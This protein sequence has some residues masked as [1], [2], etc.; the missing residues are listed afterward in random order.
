M[1]RKTKIVASLTI[2]LSG[3]GIVLILLFVPQNI[4]ALIKFSSGNKFVLPIFI[5]IWRILSNVIP[6]LPG[7]MLSIAL[8]PVLGWFPSF[9][10]TTVGVTTGAC[11]SFLL[12]R[13]FREPLVKRFVTLQ[14]INAW[15][16]KIS[17]NTEFFA[18][19]VIRITTG[20]VIDFV[21][22][23]AGLTNISFTRFFFATVISL[24]PDAFFYWA[25]E[26]AFKAGATVGTLFLVFYLLLFY[27]LK[28]RNFFK[29]L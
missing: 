3:I 14:R 28:K 6:P 26:K 16:K 10:Y 12:A 25:G 5:I 4:E 19:L 17:G 2:L 24:L 13:K 21:S 9:I 18:F 29:D 1:D 23:I 11:I 20:P 15:E 7:G 22:Y 8:V 27:I